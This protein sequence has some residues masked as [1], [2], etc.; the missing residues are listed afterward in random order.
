MTN[1]IACEIIFECDIQIKNITYINPIYFVPLCSVFDLWDIRDA[2]CFNWSDSSTAFSGNGWSKKFPNCAGATPGG[3]ET[4]K[5]N[6][7]F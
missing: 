2:S 6:H 7:E 3:I 4:F 5:L 1:S